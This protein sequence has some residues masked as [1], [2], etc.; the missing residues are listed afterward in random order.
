MEY[1]QSIP[2]LTPARCD[3][4]I[5]IQLANRVLVF[6]SVLGLFSKALDGELP[7]NFSGSRIFLSY[8]RTFDF[9]NIFD[10]V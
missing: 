7:Q 8:S 3:T 1:P 9:K 4:G 5:F 6:F 2:A 10:Q